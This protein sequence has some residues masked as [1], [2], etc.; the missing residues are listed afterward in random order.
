LLA[1]HED[2]MPQFHAGLGPVALARSAID[3]ARCRGGIAA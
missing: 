2:R 3:A 1:L